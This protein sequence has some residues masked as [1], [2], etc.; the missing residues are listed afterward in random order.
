[1][2]KELY[3]EKDLTD[4]VKTKFSHWAQINEKIKKFNNNSKLSTFNYLF[5]KD[6]ERLMKHYRND[7]DQNYEKFRTYLTQEQTNTLLINIVLN[8]ELYIQ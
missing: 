5:G 3:T 7:C 6:G 8:D 4:L 2:E 1:M